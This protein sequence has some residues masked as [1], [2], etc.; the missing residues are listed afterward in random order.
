MF[1]GSGFKRRGFGF[2]IVSSESCIVT[3]IIALAKKA[4]QTCQRTPWG[5]GVRDQ[6]KFD[7]VEKN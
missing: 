1:R 4:Q 3:L 7:K 5:T 2:R 6:K